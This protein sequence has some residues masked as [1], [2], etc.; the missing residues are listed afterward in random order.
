M[1]A[2]LTTSIPL[3]VSAADA[4]TVLGD[5]PDWSNWSRRVGFDRPA[6]PGQTQPMRVRAVGVWLT[7]P[8]RINHC[9][10]DKGLSWTGG[11]DG[12]FAGTHYFRLEPATGGTCTLV[13][14]ELFAGHLVPVMLPLLRRILLALYGEI[15]NDLARH[16]GG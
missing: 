3:P 5:L 10:L 16:L 2:E 1:T 13:Q 11:P 14:G 9:D 4:W 8:V 15:N 7:V 12:L 6:V